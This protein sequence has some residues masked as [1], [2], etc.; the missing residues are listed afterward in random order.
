L[1]YDGKDIVMCADALRAATAGAASRK[2]S[3]RLSK[4][5]KRNRKRMAE[6]GAVYDVV[7]SP[8]TPADIITTLGAPPPTDR[9]PGPLL[10][11]SG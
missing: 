2:L 8:R 6:V 7:P 11:A 4:G 3:T 5:E 10:G 1:S 9:A